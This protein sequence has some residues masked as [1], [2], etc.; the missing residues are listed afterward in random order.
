MAT[1]H[2]LST[3]VAETIRL[4]LDAKSRTQEWLADETGIPPRTLARRLHLTN[5]APMSLE[6][7]GIIAAVL[8]V[9]LVD[10]LTGVVREGADAQ[11][12]A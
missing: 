5:T 10:L 9:S 4:T 2:T 1:Q 7:L 3:K 8:E 12:V 6:E 11:A